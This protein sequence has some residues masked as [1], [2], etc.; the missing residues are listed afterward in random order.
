MTTDQILF[1]LGL[2]VV[3]AVGSQLLAGRLGIP[4]LVILL[5]VG[6]TAGALT[7]WINPNRLLGATFQPLVALAIAL[8][9]YDSG[10][11]LDLAKLKGDT[12]RVVLRLIVIGVPATWVVAMTVSVPLLGM[13]H[14]AALML[15]AILIVSGP[16]VVGPILAFVRP[17]QRLH[18][19]LSWEASLIDPIGGIVGA[20]VFVALTEGREQSFWS[21]VGTFF[22]S[23]GVGLVGGMAGA[24]LLWLL[25]KVR[26][27]A[28]MTGALQVAVVVGVAAACDIFREDTGL[29]AAIII[30]L[31]V[32][33][34]PGADPAKERPAADG[35]IQF[36]LGL[37][38]VSISSTVTPS[39]VLPVIGP[40]LGLVA[41]LVLVVRPVVA[42]IA[43]IGTDLT[44][45]ERCL[46]SW[47][48]P[49]G[50]VAAATASAF[51]STLVA[52]G[53]GGASKILPVTFL[54]IVATVTLYALTARPVARRLGV[55]PPSKLS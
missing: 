51:S 12:R 5:P 49:R 15:G 13:S 40:T 36:I 27:D 30:G 4:S 52:D 26:R 41:V 42:W 29:V 25:N 7:D 34:R 11:S 39:S 35:L 54:V 48:D 16:T 17:P 2:T 38:F 43:T 37:L 14:D 53:I 24:A 44:T 31:A 47:M 21:H 19:V 32:A 18:D 9:L 33:N 50:I 20:V 6:F 23:V 45:S 10:C 3:L 55:G 8:I 1:G 46:I 22:A 28:P